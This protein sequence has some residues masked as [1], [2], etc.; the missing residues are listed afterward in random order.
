MAA[1][2]ASKGNGPTNRSL[3]A[4]EYIGPRPSKSLSSDLILLAHALIVRPHLFVSKNPE[5]E[6]NVE[7]IYGAPNF[8]LGLKLKS[9]HVM[10]DIHYRK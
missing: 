3:V 2:G 7:N 10:G 8:V 1:G 9:C 4:V 6:T 5:N